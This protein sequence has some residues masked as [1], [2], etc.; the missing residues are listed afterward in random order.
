M[1]ENNITFLITTYKSRSII[2]DC[3]ASIPENYAKII[4]ENSND[5]E[6][7]QMIEKKFK[8]TKC[9]LM[10]SNLGYGKANNFGIMKSE[11]DFVYILNPDT[12]IYKSEFYKMLKYL[13]GEDFAICAPIVRENGNTYDNQ[14]KSEEKLKEVNSVPGMALIINKKKFNNNYFDENIFLYLEEIDLCKRIINKGE[15][16]LQVNSIVSHKGGMSHGEYNYEME[17]SRNWHWMWSKF[18]FQKKYKGFFWSFLITFP[19]LINL[20]LK[21]CLLRII[22]SNKLFIY[23]SRLSGLI[24]SILGK[25]SYFRPKL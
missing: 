25:K 8:N 12:I 15:K 3:L 9:Y 10:D 24:A 13:D 17:K 7:K 11:T 5:K 6:M 2:N 19:I 4:I 14:I 21:C 23:Q 16:I 18:Y 1:L 20:I 22:F